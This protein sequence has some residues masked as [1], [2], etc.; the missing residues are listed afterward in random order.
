MRL[1]VVEKKQVTFFCERLPRQI[2]PGPEAFLE[3]ERKAENHGL[4]R[5]ISDPFPRQGA[6]SIR[7]SSPLFCFE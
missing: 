3:R 5:I 7:A 6:V 4:G 2:R 1:L